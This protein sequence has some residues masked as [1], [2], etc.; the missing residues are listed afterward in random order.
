[1]RKGLV[2]LLRTML[3]RASVNLL[4][5]TATFLKK[6]SVLE[7]NK[8]RAKECGIAGCLVRFVP[9]SCDPLIVMTLRLLYNLSFDPDIRSQMVKAG[10]IPKLVELLKRPPYRARGLRLLYHM[11]I[12]DRCKAM[13]AYTD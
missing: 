6:L 13:F 11:S 3:D 1:V 9:C 5:L 8:D 12:D 7:E 4:Y 10:L 2:E